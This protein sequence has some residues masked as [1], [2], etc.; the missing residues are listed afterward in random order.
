[1]LNL[2]SF[3]SGNIVAV[4]NKNIIIYDINFKEIQNIINAHEDLIHYVDIQDENN[5]VTCYDDLCIKTWIKVNGLFQLNKTIKKAHTKVMNKV[6]YYSKNILISCAYDGSVKFWKDVGNGFPIISIWKTKYFGIDVE[7]WDD[8]YMEKA[9]KINKF[10]FIKD[11]KRFII[12]KDGAIYILNI[13]NLKKIRAYYGIAYLSIGDMRRISKN[14]FVIDYA[15]AWDNTGRIVV[16]SLFE[17]KIIKDMKTPFRCHGMLSIIEK[18]LL[19]VGGDTDIMIIQTNNFE[20]IKIIKN[21]HSKSIWRIKLL[22]NGFLASISHDKILKIWSLDNF[23]YKK[24]ADKY[25]K[26]QK[27]I[28]LLNEPMIEEIKENKFFK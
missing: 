24:D 15:W 17:D 4:F 6:K 13:K 26:E 1:M 25:N 7:N 12:F 19:L 22:N 21:A 28:V 5:F 16:L 23:I 20:C 11:K 10:Y 18:K 14:L 8:P 2:K 27:S 3:P 9:N